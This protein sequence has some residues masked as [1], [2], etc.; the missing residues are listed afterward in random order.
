MMNIIYYISDHV[1]SQFISII[2][3]Q[4]CF[5]TLSID[6]QRIAMAEALVSGLIQ[7]LVSLAFQRLEEEVR[8]VKDV[9]EDVQQLK[10][11]FEAIHAVLED[12][13]RR[14]FADQSVRKWMDRLKDVSFD[15]D[16]VLDEWST[17]ILK[18]K[19]DQK[20]QGV[21]LAVEQLVEHGLSSNAIMV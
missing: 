21:A 7:E 11:N 6:A 2:V 15:M 5:Q 16:T 8:L 17:A 20:Q 10:T 18:L 19:I 4:L 14:Q 9:D 12:A 1:V 13:E 3:N